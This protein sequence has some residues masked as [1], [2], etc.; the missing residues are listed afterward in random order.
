MQAYSRDRG[1]RYGRRGAA[2]N[3]P[4][5]ADAC[6]RTEPCGGDAP[7][8]PAKLGAELTV[9]R[10]RLGPSTALHEGYAGL[11]YDNSLLDLR[12]SDE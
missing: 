5:L 3:L 12:R 9:S 11:R 1:R 10:G 2:G 6:T 7:G 8:A 4:L